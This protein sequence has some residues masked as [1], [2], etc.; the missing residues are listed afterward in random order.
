M[1]LLCLPTECIDEV[2]RHLS[3]KPLLALC[4]ASKRLN[5]ISTRLIYR[6]LIF[7]SPSKTILCC[8]TLISNDLAA[9]AV[10]ELQVLNIRM[11]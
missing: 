8:R 11:R 7:E 5:A 6:K 10:R 1:S 9:Q 2:A 3:Q 4:L